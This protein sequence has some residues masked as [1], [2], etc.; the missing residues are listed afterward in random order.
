[1]AQSQQPDPLAPF[2]EQLRKLA[3]ETGP[4]E[5]LS[6]ELYRFKGVLI[7]A[8]YMCDELAFMQVSGYH[9]FTIKAIET[10]VR[11]ALSILR[12]RYKTEAFSLIPPG[13]LYLLYESNGQPDIA[14]VSPIAILF[15]R[16]TSNFLTQWSTASRLI[17]PLGDLGSDMF[18]T[19][20]RKDVYMLRITATGGRGALSFYAFGFAKDL[21]D[22]ANA[23]FAI[24]YRRDSID[25]MFIG[26]TMHDFIGTKTT[27]LPV[28]LDWEIENLRDFL[29]E[30][31]ANAKLDMWIYIEAG[32]NQLTLQAYT[33]PQVKKQEVK[34]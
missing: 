13:L 31:I 10:A 7:D 28:Y 18:E 11:G 33:P 21:R 12:M 8:V 20:N 24:L 19:I 34:K 15:V 4:I 30:A 3:E 16:P 26:L 9:E 32:S 1:M 25:G 27:T 17:L 6:N 14:A 29:A 5:C 22:V 2:K 23:P